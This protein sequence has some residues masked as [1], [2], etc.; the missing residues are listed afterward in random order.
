[1]GARCARLD[2][3]LVLLLQREDLAELHVRRVVPLDGVGALEAVGRRLVLLQVHVA[4]PLIVPDL[5]V[6][7]A[8]PLCLLV[9]VQ[10]R[11][12]LAQQVERAAHLLEVADVVRVEARRRLEELQRLLYLAALALDQ[13]LD[14]DRIL[15]HAFALFQNLFD[16]G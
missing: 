16:G 9:D 1:M 8:Y 5:P 4:Q 13:R 7:D 11:L 15:R 10:R 12:V 6:V 2:G 14:V 3:G